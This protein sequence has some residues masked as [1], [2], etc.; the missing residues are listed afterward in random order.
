M[1]E[2]KVSPSSSLTFFFFIFSLQHLGEIIATDQIHI[3]TIVMGQET[4]TAVPALATR[5]QAVAVATVAVA[6]TSGVV[7]T[8]AALGV[9]LVVHDTVQIHAMADLIH[10]T[11]ALIHVM[12]LQTPDKIPPIP[13]TSPENYGTIWP[14][15][16]GILA[17][18]NVAVETLDATAVGAC[19]AIGDTNC[20]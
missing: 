2:R 11:A 8:M 6:A 19:I 17:A 14:Q 16:L 12:A 7:Q 18:S 3:P 9:V 13:G 4:T 5:I 15:A 10:A 20:K 1:K